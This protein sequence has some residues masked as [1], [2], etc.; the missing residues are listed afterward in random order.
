[1]VIEGDKGT[2]ALDPYQGD[3]FTVT[4]AAGVQR[5][6]A[7]PGLTR[8]QAYQASYVDTHQHF[9]DCLLS[10]E[11]AENEASDNLG[12]LAA[13]FAAYDSAEH[14]QVILIGDHGGH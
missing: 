9:V 4:T 8:A 6:P 3:V 12:T 2:I 11:P 13:A 5:R 14:N 7:R 10:G 1:M